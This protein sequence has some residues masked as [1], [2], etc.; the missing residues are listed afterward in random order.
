MRDGFGGEE[1]K[2]GKGGLRTA[3]SLPGW[4]AGSLNG[5]GRNLKVTTF[6]FPAPSFAF[7]G[8][9]PVF[10]MEAAFRASVYLFLSHG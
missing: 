9:F 2:L 6:V 1:I 7:C 10:V 5:I 4:V 3:L 8:C